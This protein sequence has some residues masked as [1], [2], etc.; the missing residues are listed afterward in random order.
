MRCAA[1]LSQQHRHQ[2]PWIKCCENSAERMVGSV[3][4]CRT[5]INALTRGP[6]R[7]VTELRIV[8]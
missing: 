2:Q 5:H 3:P 1:V 6:V 8:S 4:L 7:A